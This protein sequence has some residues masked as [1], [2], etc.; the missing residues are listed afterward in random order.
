MYGNA[1]REVLGG[2]DVAV[3]APR[4]CTV[5]CAMLNCTV[6]SAHGCGLELNPANI[7]MEVVLEGTRKRQT[8]RY[9]SMAPALRGN[10]ILVRDYAHYQEMEAA[11]MVSVVEATFDDTGLMTAMVRVGTVLKAKAQWF[12]TKMTPCDPSPNLLDAM[13]K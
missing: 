1:A 6:S 12:A 10:S 9:Q 5:R 3:S 11:K 8:V 4:N 2:W 13:P 7:E